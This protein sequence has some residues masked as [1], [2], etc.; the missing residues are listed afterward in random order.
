MNVCGSGGLST[1][2]QKKAW[3]LIMPV[4]PIE[5]FELAHHVE[6]SNEDPRLCKYI[7]TYLWHAVVIYITKWASIAAMFLT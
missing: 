4:P 7:R 6:T 3:N 2:I 1:I 5:A